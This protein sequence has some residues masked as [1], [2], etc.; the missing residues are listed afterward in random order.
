MMLGQVFGQL[1]YYLDTDG[2]GR[3]SQNEIASAADLFPRY[4]FPVDADMRLSS[5]DVN[6]DGQGCSSI[7]ILVGPESGPEPGP[8]HVWSFDF[9]TCLNLLGPEIFLPMGY[10]KLGN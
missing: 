3:I 7:D 6:S 9:E 4:R 2:N 1:Q 10:V 5:F 8:T